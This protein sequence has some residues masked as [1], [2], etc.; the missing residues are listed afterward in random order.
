MKNQIPLIRERVEG[1]LGKHSE[2]KNPFLKMSFN[3]IPTTIGTN[4]KMI[5]SYITNILK[6]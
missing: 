6:A 2:V 3:G 1:Q 4:K 5:V